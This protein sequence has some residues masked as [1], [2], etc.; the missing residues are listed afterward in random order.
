MPGLHLSLGFASQTLTIL[1]PWHT[2]PV[3]SQL[4]GGKAREVIF[5]SLSCQPPQGLDG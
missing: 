2:S 3:A 4:L 1:H 5:L